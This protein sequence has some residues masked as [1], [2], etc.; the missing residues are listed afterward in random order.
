MPHVNFESEIHTA[1]ALSTQLTELLASE[2]D[3]FI[4]GSLA[5]AVYHDLSGYDASS[6][7]SLRGEHPLQAYGHAR[8]I[9]VLTNHQPQAGANPF[10]VD[11]EA[12]S[13]GHA[14]LVRTNGDWWLSAEAH[15]FAEPVDIAVMEPH[16]GKTIYDIPV[17]TVPLQT[18]QA[19]H[20]IRGIPRRKE[21][22]SAQLLAEHTADLPRPLPAE[23]YAPFEK[24]HTMNVH[25]ASPLRTFYRR[26]TSIGLDKRFG[27]TIVKCGNA[28]GRIGMHK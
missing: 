16:H 5:R 20:K 12:F 28:L 6:E 2:P 17:R 23:L 18:L 11:T 27:D 21:T 19:L 9:D 22:L 7:Y 24:L 25:A 26:N 8:D 4:V 13:Y 3:V 1:E 15:N 10:P 14:N